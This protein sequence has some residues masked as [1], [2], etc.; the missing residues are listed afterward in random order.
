[1]RQL[2]EGSNQAN[3]AATS[4]SSVA[5]GPSTSAT[6]SA[7][8]F[9]NDFPG[10]SP[11]KAPPRAISSGGSAG[12]QLVT[13]FQQK[14]AKLSSKGGRKPGEQAGSSSGGTSSSVKYQVVVPASFGRPPAQPPLP[15]SGPLGHEGVI[16]G[17]SSSVIAAASPVVA[18][19]DF[20][21]DAA[22]DIIT[23]RDQQP[24]LL[25]PRSK[26][27]KDASSSG[28]GDSSAVQAAAPAAASDAAA[29]AAALPLRPGLQIRTSTGPAAAAATAA[30][31]QLAATNIKARLAH[32]TPPSALPA[33]AATPTSISSE[34]S[35]VLSPT[36][37]P[38]S[39]PGSAKAAF[40]GLRSPGGRK[41]WRA[42]FAFDEG[43]SDTEGSAPAAAAAVM[44]HTDLMSVLGGGSRPARG[45]LL[46][47]NHSAPAALTGS[48]A[49][50][51]HSA[52]PVLTGNS[53]GDAVRLVS[54]PKAGSGAASNDSSQVSTGSGITWQAQYG[55]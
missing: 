26:P 18:A 42:T 25:Q 38:R 4:G 8:S 13:W 41:N 21:S 55:V 24:R 1:V 29:A 54:G 45:P 19:A 43:G 32:V 9:Q 6:T 11:H 50:P 31:S 53:A 33:A 39:R 49:A 44:P 10:F 7:D 46:P 47:V 34:E 17:T 2:F 51:L 16:A 5:G 37:S 52:M 20:V 27:A 30:P 28:A 48:G 12:A 23:A 35:G 40:G 3:A 22:A 15:A 36:R 14:A